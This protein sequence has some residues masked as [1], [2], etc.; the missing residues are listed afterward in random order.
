MS[1]LNK[2]WMVVSVMAAA[3]GVACSHTAPPAEA[4][5]ASSATDKTPQATIKTAASRL[6]TQQ[7]GITSWQIFRSKSSL[8]MTGY[9]KNGKA[10]KGLQT[11]FG[12]AKDGSGQIIRTHLLDGSKFAVTHGVK[13]KKT[14]ANMTK[15]PATTKAF[16]QAATSDSAKIHSLFHSQAVSPTHSASDQCGADL[17]TI[18]TKALSCMQGKANTKAEQAACIA[19]AQT[20]ASQSGGSCAGVGTTSSKP[21]SSSG[22]GSTGGSAAS[23]PASSSAAKKSSGSASEQRRQQLRGGQEELVVQLLVEHLVL[24]LLLGRRHVGRTMSTTTTPPTATTPTATTTRPATTT[25]TR[26]TPTTW[27]ARMKRTASTATTTTPPP[28]TTTTPPSTTAT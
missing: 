12:Q 21:A 23:K 11:G 17:S 2:R 8:I 20:A 10:V 9:D 18:V 26:S 16:V 24:V 6:T 15:M 7:F 27:T 22:G 28:A 13:N 5:N 19:S 25:T 4:Q 1:I 3:M 14:L